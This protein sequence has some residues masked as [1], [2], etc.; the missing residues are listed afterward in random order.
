MACDTLPCMSLHTAPLTPQ[1]E[2]ILDEYRDLTS[3]EDRLTCLMERP[4]L[5]PLLALEECSDGCK[6]PGCLSGLW[7]TGTTER[8]R[9]YFRCRSESQVVQ[10]VVSL[11][12]DLASGQVPHDVQLV[13]QRLLPVLGLEQLLSMTR[14]AAIAKTVSFMTTF[15][16]Q[17]GPQVEQSK[18]A[19]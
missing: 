16:A 8:G 2:A 13:T 7:I 9:C 15:A 12:C 6:V 1:Q 5:K 10:G 11:L 19:A 17:Q 3:A 4:P 14:K 18:E